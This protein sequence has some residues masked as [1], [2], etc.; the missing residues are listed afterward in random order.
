MLT[1]G[2]GFRELKYDGY[3][4]DNATKQE[5]DWLREEKC[6]CSMCSMNFSAFLCRTPQNNNVK[7]PNFRF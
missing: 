6:L 4:N 7:S 1:L 5:Y 2:P 3:D